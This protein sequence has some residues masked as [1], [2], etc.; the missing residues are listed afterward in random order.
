MTGQQR[1]PLSDLDAA[2]ANRDA[3]MAAADEHAPEGWADQALTLVAAY[4]D[5]HEF[6]FPPHWWAWAADHGLAPP[7][8]AR[9]FGPVVK[10]AA[11]AGIIAPTGCYWPSPSSH[12][13]PKQIWRSRRYRG[14]RTGEYLGRPI[15]LPR[16]RGA[17]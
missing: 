12:A 7:P 9:A 11:L 1:F 4:C 5:E 2:R 17:A 14:P 10:R 3:G 8:Q 13:S 16:V 6:L 15:D